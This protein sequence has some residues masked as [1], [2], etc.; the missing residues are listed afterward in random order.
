MTTINSVTDIRVWLY[1]TGIEPETGEELAIEGETL[2][3]LHEQLPRSYRGPKIPA[4]D[5]AGFLKGWIGPFGWAS[6]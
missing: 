3:E 4:Y 2:Q 1:A 6:L 5:A